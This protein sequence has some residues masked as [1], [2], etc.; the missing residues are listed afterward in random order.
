M[1]TCRVFQRIARPLLITL[2][3]VVLALF[4]REV[5]ALSLAKPPA[6]TA[7]SAILIEEDTGKV[8]YAYNADEPFPPASLTKMVT[9]EI[10]LDQIDEGLLDPA[11]IVVPKANAWAVNQPTGSSLMFLGPHQRL[12]IEQLLEGLTIASG[13]DAA[14]ELADLVAG[15]VSDFVELM[16]QEVER[17]GFRQMHFVDPA[18]IH[19]GNR[20]T[21]REYAEFCRR[22]IRLHPDALPN[23]LSVKK[24]VYPLSEN[25]TDGNREQPIVQFNR[26]LLLWKNDGVDGLKTGYIDQSGYNSAVTAERDGMRLIAVVLG[27]PG[28]IGD[29]AAEHQREVESEAL[30]D[31]G[32]SN[33]VLVRPTYEPPSLVRVWKGRDQWVDLAPASEPVAV[34]PRSEAG[35]VT[36]VIRQEREAVA[37]IRQGQPLGHLVVMA[38]GKELATFPLEATHPVA[39]GGIFRRAV[40]SV[41]LWARGLFGSHARAESK[42]GAQIPTKRSARSL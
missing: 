27:I 31:W 16:N 23:L 25:L 24:I 42:P 41:W 17:L 21:A 4:P 37:P 8:L 39:R 9:L 6:L 34:V 14:V 2:G 20:I 30:L 19:S 40:D 1:P 15:S 13:N 3:L 11:Q 10:V 33:F 22:F 35:S 18:G 32:F 28:H 36:G 7:K 26:N 5:P 38:G 12:T 29:T